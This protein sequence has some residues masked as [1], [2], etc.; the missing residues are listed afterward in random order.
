MEQ[1]HA[2]S[3]VKAG[4]VADIPLDSEGKRGEQVHVL[5]PEPPKVSSSVDLVLRWKSW[6]ERA[7]N[8]AGCG[9]R[10]TFQEGGDVSEL[11]DAILSVA[12]LLL[13]LQQAVQ[14]LPA[15]QAGVDAAQLPVHLPPLTTSHQHVVMV[16]SHF[17]MF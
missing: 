9:V 1:K 13:Q 10:L 7:R 5:F 12:T 17:N 8:V 11:R 15:G 3:S 4:R 14:E 16:T 6:P 2:L